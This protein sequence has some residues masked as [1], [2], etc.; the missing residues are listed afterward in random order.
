MAND[1]PTIKLPNSS[2]YVGPRIAPWVLRAIN[3]MKS[4][5]LGAEKR[6]I[7]ENVQN[8]EL[9]ELVG[10]GNGI[11]KPTRRS[12]S[13]KQQLEGEIRF[14]LLKALH[15]HQQRM[16]LQW[17]GTFL[18]SD[19]WKAKAAREEGVGILYCFALQGFVLCNPEA[20]NDFLCLPKIA[21][22]WSVYIFSNKKYILEKVKVNLVKTLFLIHILHQLP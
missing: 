14:P 18:R 2:I 15:G 1:C 3:Q 5:I 8:L 13:I 19:D 22:C 21:I 4:C 17:F 7:V 10:G 9:A 20:W 6:W 12:P 16:C 11:G